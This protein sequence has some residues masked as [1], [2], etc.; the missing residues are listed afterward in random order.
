MCEQTKSLSINDV[1]QNEELKELFKQHC[2]K[3]LTIESFFFITKVEEYNGTVEK[4]E[5]AE[6]IYETFLKE[7]SP[8]EIN[9]CKLSLASIVENLE[10]K[11]HKDN[12][13]EEI[14]REICWLLRDTFKRFKE[15]EIY[16]NYFTSSKT[17][18]E[19]EKRGIDRVRYSVANI[20]G[21]LKR[22]SS[23]KRRKNKPRREVKDSVVLSNF[24]PTFAL[25]TIHF[26]YS[27][28]SNSFIHS[29]MQS[30]PNKIYQSLISAIFKPLQTNKF[31]GEKISEITTT[32]KSQLVNPEKF[33]K[34]HLNLREIYDHPA[35][36][37]VKQLKVSDFKD[38]DIAE[39]LAIKQTNQNRS[40]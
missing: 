28:I 9:T 20:F 27:L 36:G 24:S 19:E 29:N 12:L 11:N 13:F 1:F 15:S 3:E 10:K 25:F 33:L 26:T 30:E 17:E 39:I 8:Y 4:H 21:G 16:K 38:K 2:F 32:F 23:P 7:D 22:R 14:Q 34:H 35:E 6:E 18:E 5:V 40:C 31:E 37:L